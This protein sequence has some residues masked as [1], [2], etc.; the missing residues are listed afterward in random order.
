MGQRVIGTG[1]RAIANCPALLIA[2]QDLRSQH[3]TAHP[4]VLTRS[5]HQSGMATPRKEPSFQSGW[6]AQDNEPSQAAYNPPTNAADA[7]EEDI[8]G[9]SFMVVS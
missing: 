8:S 1:Y 9:P 6:A 4:R 7:C 3:S 5:T 2:N